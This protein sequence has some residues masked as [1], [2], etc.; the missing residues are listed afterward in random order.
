MLRTPACAAVLMVLASAPTWASDGQIEIN[1]AVAM[2][3]GVNGDLGLDPPGYPVTITQSGSY[4]ITSFMS[5]PNAN[6]DGIVV[7]AL[8]VAIDFGGFEL[9]GP[10]QVAVAGGSCTALGSGV[11]VRSSQSV[12]LHD[13]RIAGMGSGGVIAGSE[14]RV[15]RM[16]LIQNCGNGAVLG[17]ASFVLESEARL[18]R[19]RG[20]EVG[21][22]SRVRDSI[23]DA[24]GDVGIFGGEGALVT[25]NIA[26]A[27]IGVGIRVGGGSVVNENVAAA[28]TDVGIVAGSHSTVVHNAAS[29]A[30]SPRISRRL[31]QLSPTSLAEP[32]LAA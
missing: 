4:R 11:G 3:G 13:G 23:A 8:R 5:V 17:G 24:N 10:N 27:N 30:E 2:A 32:V 21:S 18:N 9:R 15:E 16:T 6:T 19:V 28:P 31:V 29:S 14:S 26:T 1:H 25:G 22:S 7:T 20:F 12:H